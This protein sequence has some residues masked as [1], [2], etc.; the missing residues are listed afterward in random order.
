MK[1]S[2]SLPPGVAVSR[3]TQTTIS[4][5]ML[6]KVSRSL[7]SLFAYNSKWQVVLTREGLLWV[8]SDPR[9]EYCYRSP[10]EVINLVE[11][12]IDLRVLEEMA[13]MYEGGRDI[14]AGG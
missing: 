12:D 5:P 1:R 14:E 8:I 6:K 2:R 10:D 11:S 9:P 4:L 13:E 7:H 3:Y